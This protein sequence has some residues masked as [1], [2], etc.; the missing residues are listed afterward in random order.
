L[1]FLW[2]KGACIVLSF[3]MLLPTWARN[4]ASLRFTSF[5]QLGRAES[6]C[7]L[8]WCHRL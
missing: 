4:C 8:G 3:Q 1:L 5:C 7:S 6:V 2:S